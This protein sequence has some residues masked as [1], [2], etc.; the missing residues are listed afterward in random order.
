MKLCNY[1]DNA[2]DDKAVLCVHCGRKI[3]T[4]K[5]IFKKWWFWVIIAVVILGI[6][7]GSS[8]S[9]EQPVDN[10]P[11]SSNVENSGSAESQQ[12]PSSNEN[13]AEQ[14]PALPEEFS[15]SCP[16]SISASIDDDIIGYPEIKCNIKNKS[17][18]EIAA[19]KLYFLPTDVYGEEVNSIFT[20]NDLYTDN[21]IAAGKSATR[22]W[23]LLDQ[24]VKG[25]DIYVYSVYFT[26]G[27]EWGDKDAS[28]SKI[29]KYGL[30]LTIE[31]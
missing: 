17:N 16:V 10:A 5:S 26:D 28:R 11:P 29:K 20:E 31:N 3:K 14:K 21:P 9:A 19:V 25:G 30:K 27:T 1:C 7:A 2:I 13:K 15:D 24:E 18:K 22:S 12:K 8:G 4:K 23:Q 6:A